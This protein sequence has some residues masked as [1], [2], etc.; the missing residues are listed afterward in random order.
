MSSSSSPS[1]DLDSQVHKPQAGDTRAKSEPHYQVPFKSSMPS[2]LYFTVP[3]NERKSFP[4][5]RYSEM[6]VVYLPR[7]SEITGAKPPK[8]HDQGKT[9]EMTKKRLLIATSSPITYWKE[10]WAIIPTLVTAMPLMRRRSLPW[11]R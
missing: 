4:R 5:L 10:S 3:T 7:L 6:G 9:V 1:F 2:L 11:H 8:G